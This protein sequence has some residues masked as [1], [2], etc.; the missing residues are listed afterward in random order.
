MPVCDDNVGFVSGIHRLGPLVR[1]WTMHFEAR[2]RYFKR[3][4]SQL[5]NFINVPYTLAMRHQQ[6]QSYY[7]LDTS[8]IG[9]EQPEIGPGCSVSREMVSG[10]TLP[11]CRNLY[12]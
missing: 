3:L 7:N 4:A 12:R 10:L 1:H 11:T 8:A 6:Q 2:N 5:G 9:G